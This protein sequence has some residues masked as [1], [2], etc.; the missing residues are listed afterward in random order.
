MRYLFLTVAIL[1]AVTTS[2]ANGFQLPSL[3]PAPNPGGGGGTPTVPWKFTQPVDGMQC[4]G[5]VLFA[6]TGPN[7]DSGGLSVYSYTNTIPGGVLASELQLQISVI[8]DTDPGIDWTGPIYEQVGESY[9]T[10]MPALGT[11]NIGLLSLVGDGGFGGTGTDVGTLTS[12]NG[13][14]GVLFRILE[15]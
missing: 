3:N 5:N 15:P 12:L 6:G 1:F 2:S 8:V 14:Q 10:I 9:A 7:S 11:P 4:Y 13:G